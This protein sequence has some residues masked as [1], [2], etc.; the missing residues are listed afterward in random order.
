MMFELSFFATISVMIFIVTL[1]YMTNLRSRRTR[2]LIL[3]TSTAICTAIFVVYIMT[4]SS[5]SE[6]ASSAGE[7]IVLEDTCDVEISYGSRAYLEAMQKGRECE[8]TDL[9]TS[10]KMECECE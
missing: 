3:L 5:E 8:F 9:G 2:T 4:I 10:W 6:V 1:I 7:T